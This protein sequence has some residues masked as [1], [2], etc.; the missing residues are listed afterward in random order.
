MGPPK[1]ARIGCADRGNGAVP[2][3]LTSSSTRRIQ[4]LLRRTKRRRHEVMVRPADCR[5]HSNR[6][7]ARLRRGH[8]GVDLNPAR[9][10]HR[11]SFPPNARSAVGMIVDVVPPAGS[12][13]HRPGFRDVESRTR[14]KV[15]RSASL[16]PPTLT[17]P[18]CRRARL[19]S[20]CRSV[21]GLESFFRPPVSSCGSGRFPPAELLGDRHLSEICPT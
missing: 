16:P 4:R 8:K 11:G 14:A 21:A 2:P 7:T 18:G 20:F 3:C 12:C 5:D 9:R 13:W 6:R 19:S 15:E 1:A 10:P 17:T